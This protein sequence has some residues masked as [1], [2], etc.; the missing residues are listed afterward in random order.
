MDAANPSAGRVSVVLPCF[1]EAARLDARAILDFVAADPGVDLL[2]VNDGSTDDTAKS[3]SALVD[4]RPDRIQLLSLERNRG[5]AEAV[6]AGI[7]QA[8]DR[9]PRYVGYWDSDLATPIGDVSAFASLLDARPELQVIF[10]ARVKLLGRRIE[11]SP[12]RHFAGR[13]FAT[14]VSQ[15][16]D[17]AI[18]DTQC[19]AKMF[20]VTP[21]L[22]R[23]FEEPFQSGWVFDVEILARMIERIRHER[24]EPIERVIYEYPLFEWRDVPGSKVDLRAYLRSAIQVLRIRR[25]YLK[26]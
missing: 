7:L 13:I 4:S 21:R 5:K 20:R 12:Y 26:G 22:G 16:L 24:G 3:L 19:G 25:R 18:Y 9:A 11:R 23:L 1:N 6:R 17:L 8:L 14:V 2:F 10:G 15:M